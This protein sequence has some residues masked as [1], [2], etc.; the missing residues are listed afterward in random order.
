MKMAN[1]NTADY[2][3]NVAFVAAKELFSERELK[4]GD[5][6]SFAFQSDVTTVSVEKVENVD[7]RAFDN[8]VCFVQNL[9][10]WNAEVSVLSVNNYCNSYFERIV[11][12]GTDAVPFIM[13]EM[14]KGPTPLVHAL[15]LIFPGVMEYEGYVS[16]KEACDKWISILKETAVH[17]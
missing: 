3:E 7:T 1:S 15:D 16:M 8:R 2:V 11:E 13:E 5:E 6:P 17:S 14:E 12:M 9:K 4:S 10:Y